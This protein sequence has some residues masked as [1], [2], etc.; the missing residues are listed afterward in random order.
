M[1][2]FLPDPSQ[3]PS[4]TPATL[5]PSVGEIVDDATDLLRADGELKPGQGT[6]TTAIALSLGVMSF[7]GVLA[8]LF[9]Q[10]LT[11]PELRKAYNVDW[12]RALLFSGLLV[13]GTLSLFNIVFNRRRTVNIV[14]FAFVLVTILL[15]GSTVPVG[16]FPD[17][18]PYLGM[19]WLVLDLLGS[20]TVFVILEKMFPLY[21]NQPIFRKEWQT[22]LIHFGVNHL[23]VGLMLLIVNFVIHR[24]QVIVVGEEGV[25]QFISTIPFLPQLLLCLLVADLAEYAV[26]RAY[27]EVP[28]LWRIH[29][30]HHSVETLDWLAGSRLHMAEILVTRIAVLTPLFLLGFDKSV[31]D[32]YIVIVGFQA[33]FNH[34][35]VHLPWGPL[36]YLI[37]TP[38]F[39]HWHHSSEKVAID[40][41]YAAHFSFI[42]YVFGTA[43]KTDRQFPEKYGVVGSRIPGGYLQQ[44]A[45]PFKKSQG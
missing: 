43:V 8:F 6:I 35:N 4:N 12:C 20:T 26:H 42:D 9:P 25:Q 18:T 1:S 30:V 33:V 24:A 17:H 3:G 29:S 22:D 2:N 10:Y 34:A 13:S 39:H 7:L 37:V 40:K 28:W 23:L 36:K 41:N 32:M 27:H 31:V 44:Q 38:D 21:K 45:Y 19:D 5:L 11:T 16:D 14:A 15:G